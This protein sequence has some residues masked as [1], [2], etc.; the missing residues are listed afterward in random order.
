MKNLKIKISIPKDYLEHRFNLMK[1]T[2][3]NPNKN[4]INRSLT[5][6]ILCV[7]LFTFATQSTAQNVQWYQPGHEWFYKSWCSGIG[8]PGP[9]GYSHYSVQFVD[10]IGEE[11]VSI[12]LQSDYNESGQHLNTTYHNFKTSG[13][14]VFHL[15]VP[16][17]TW[18]LLYSFN[19][20]VGE[21]WVVQGD[22]YVGYGLQESLEDWRF[23]VVVDSITTEEIGGIMRR[24]V[25]TSFGLGDE[26]TN[27]SIFNFT[28]GI[29]E[30]IGSVGMEMFGDGIAFIGIPGAFSCFIEDEVTIY[31]PFGYPC[32]LLS[33]ED[34]TLDEVEI[35][36]NPATNE[37]TIRHSNA[38]LPITKINIHDVSGRLI[39]TDLHPG[40]DT[41]FN[42]HNLQSGMYLLS[43][44]TAEGSVT[45]KL[46]ID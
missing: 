38:S 21:S 16:S 18:Y 46:M 10:T 23:E 15:Y 35:F 32:N 3:L 19:T 8:G 44:Y 25:H 13:D 12:V 17:E 26:E 24:K 9:C 28:E 29:I 39:F 11:E 43:I 14:S 41:K 27:P 22:V 6:I 36:P 2:N 31:G 5:K 1:S 30:G 45:K 4:F 37:V 7:A 20:P 33:T 42:V 40:Q 34:I